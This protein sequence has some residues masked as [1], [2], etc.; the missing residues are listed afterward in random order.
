MGSSPDGI[1]CY[2]VSF[3]DEFEFPWSEDGE[4]DSWWRDVRG[5]AHPQGGP[6]DGTEFNEDGRSN[7]WTDD[8]IGEYYDHRRQWEKDN[9]LPVEEV[10][11]YSY[12]ANA[13]VLAVP[14]TVLTSGDGEALEFDPEDLDRKVCDGA[15]AL[16]YQFLAKYELAPQ[17]N[18]S[19]ILTSFYG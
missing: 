17:P 16:F 12:D 19:W 14:G 8:N 5:Y 3:P 7:G 2:G 4:I 10:R 9:P 15:L 6:H 1:I 13:V 11:C 18:P